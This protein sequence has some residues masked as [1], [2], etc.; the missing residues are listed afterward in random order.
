MFE[1]SIT[2]LLY[3]S[4]PNLFDAMINSVRREPVW[5]LTTKLVSMLNGVEA[6]EWFNLKLD[7][8]YYRFDHNNSNHYEL[9]TH[10]NTINF[11]MVS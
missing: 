10:E 1:Q 4:V 7:V 11:L 9:K 6:K 8:I 5:T 3:L 2:R